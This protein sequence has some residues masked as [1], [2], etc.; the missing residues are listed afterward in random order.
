MLYNDLDK[1]PLDIIHR[2]IYRRQQQTYYRGKT[3]KRRA[4]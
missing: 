1:I 3:F 4:F 2:C